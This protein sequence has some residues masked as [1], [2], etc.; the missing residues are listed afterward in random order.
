MCIV[1]NF[2]YLHVCICSTAKVYCAHLLLF[3]GLSGVIAFVHFVSKLQY[4]KSM[5]LL[6]SSLLCLLYWSCQ[7]NAVC[8]DCANMA[9]IVIT[10]WKK[11][12]LLFYHHHCYWCYY[13]SCFWY[14]FNCC[15]VGDAIIDYLHKAFI[16][17]FVAFELSQHRHHC[18]VNVL[19]AF[20]F[21]HML[22]FILFC[23]QTLF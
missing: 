11:S 8:F 20:S 6:C 16:C 19:L 9:A 14:Q 4:H 22:C 15:F 18:S 2:F 23:T 17:L 13:C 5:H 3:Y 1:F 7:T 21:H 12:L 10:L